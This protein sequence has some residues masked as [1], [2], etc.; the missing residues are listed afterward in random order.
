MGEYAEY[1]LE[2]INKKQIC[3]MKNALITILTF[4]LISPYCLAEDE[5][6]IGAMLHISGEWARQGI[7][8]KEGIELAAQEINKGGGVNGKQ[9]KLVIEDTKYLPAVTH[10]VAKKLIEVDKVVAALVTTASETKTAG[11]LFERAKVPIISLWDSS[12]ELEKMGDYIFAIGTWAP[13]SGEV[14]AKYAYENLNAKTAIVINSQTGWSLSVT[15]PFEKQFSE[16]GGNVL[17]IFSNSPEESDYKSVLLKTKA[18]NPDVIYAPIDGNLLPFFK[19]IYQLKLTTPIISSDVIAPEQTEQEPEVF[20]GIY[21][22]QTADPDSL[23]SKTLMKKYKQVFSKDAPFPLFTAWGYDGLMLAVEGIKNGA[24]TPQEIGKKLY[25]VEDFEGA[26]GTL[27][28]NKF[29]SSRTAVRMFQIKK[30]QFKIL[31]G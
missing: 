10:T 6:R 18:L 22:T 8:F 7:A 12:P 29:G 14:A 26:S 24:K 23:K 19:Q 13:S 31:P 11:P 20:E 28:I 5:I 16:L 1:W 2:L 21:Q 25:A 17:K 4:L 15:D 3:F 9:V 27:S 30:G